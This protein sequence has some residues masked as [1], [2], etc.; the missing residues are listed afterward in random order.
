VGRIEGRIAWQADN[1]DLRCWGY[2]LQQPLTSDADT[3]L[4]DGDAVVWTAAA[5]LCMGRLGG[6]EAKY[7]QMLLTLEKKA[8]MARAASVLIEHPQ[9]RTVRS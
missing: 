5:A 2:K 9:T 8:E 6:P 7:G 4:Y 1:L 3:C